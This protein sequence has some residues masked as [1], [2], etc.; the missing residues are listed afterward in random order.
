MEWCVKRPR[1][2]LRRGL[3]PQ[4]GIVQSS[5]TTS[6]MVEVSIFRFRSTPQLAVA[7]RKRIGFPKSAMH[8]SAWPS[9]GSS[10]PCGRG[11]RV[12]ALTHPRQT[13]FVHPARQVRDSRVTSEAAGLEGG[14]FLDEV[15]LAAGVAPIHQLIHPMLVSRHALKIAASA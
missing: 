2:L 5:R 9:R 7:G 6:L 14:S 12:G 11:E 4:R 1:G 13:V 10:G 3:T 8:V 15:G